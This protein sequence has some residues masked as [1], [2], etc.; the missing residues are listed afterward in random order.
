MDKLHALVMATSW[1]ALGEEYYS[2]ALNILAIQNQVRKGEGGGKEG[3]GWRRG[4]GRSGRKELGTL[5][6]I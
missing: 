5:T 4:R 6:D 1:V 3:G 2:N